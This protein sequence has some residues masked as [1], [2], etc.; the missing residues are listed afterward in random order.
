VA[1]KLN[2]SLRSVGGRAAQDIAA[3]LEQRALEGA[4]DD[5]TALYDSLTR[6]LARLDD[7]IGGYLVGS[8]GGNGS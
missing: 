6:E 1:H 4:L 7:A 2:G 5:A 8:G 3:L